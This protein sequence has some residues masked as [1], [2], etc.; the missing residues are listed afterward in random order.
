MRQSF[1]WSKQEYKSSKRLS[2]T[3]LLWKCIRRGKLKITF[4]L[5]KMKDGCNHGFREVFFLCNAFRLYFLTICQ[6]LFLSMS[7]FRG[8]KGCFFGVKRC[9]T[10]NISE[11]NIFQCY[12]T[13]TNKN[14][15][16]SALHNVEWKIFGKNIL[17]AFKKSK[18]GKN[19]NSVLLWCS[20]FCP[21]PVFRLSVL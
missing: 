4:E 6:E 3:H 15:T 10:C 19:R 16:V 1:Y 18:Y 9:Y 12:C 11:K 8:R 21:L 17:E 13:S 20:L 5:K 7:D 14:S 2:G